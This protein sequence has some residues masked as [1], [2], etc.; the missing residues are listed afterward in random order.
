VTD[1]EPRS[2]DG[3]FEQC[4]ATTRRMI[5]ATGAVAQQAADD[6]ANGSLGSKQLIKTMTHFLDIGLLGSMELMETIVAGPDANWAPT[7]AESD[8]FYVDGDDTGERRL[9]IST[10]LTYMGSA[11]EVPCERVSFKPSAGRDAHQMPH[12]RIAAGH[13]TFRI[14]VDSRELPSGIYVG[15]VGVRAAGGPVTMVAVQIAL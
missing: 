4:A 12:G 9:F 13:N 15:E 6:L 10:P 11:D 14:T 5:R 2:F 3:F 1:P 7:T 8:D